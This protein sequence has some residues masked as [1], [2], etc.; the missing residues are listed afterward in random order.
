[1]TVGAG[2]KHGMIRRDFVQVLTSRK[3]GRFPKCF[4]PAAASD[5]FSGWS[6]SGALGKFCQKVGEGVGA[7]EVESQFAFADSK[8]VA[9]RIGQPRKERSIM[10]IDH[11]RSMKSPG[12]I[13]GSDEQNPPTF[14]GNGLGA[15][16]FV[17]N[18][19]NISIEKEE[20]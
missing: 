15:R 6:F 11:A 17:V 19:I 2:E 4:D 9:V 18:G 1:M 7:F 5:P 14:N 16:L 10:K 8:N 3:P 20:I 12:L 13:V